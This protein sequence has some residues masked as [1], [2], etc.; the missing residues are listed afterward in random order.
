LAAFAPDGQKLWGM[1]LERTGIGSCLPER[2][3]SGR[4]LVVRCFDW[5]LRRFQILGE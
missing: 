5:Y 1:N 2:V 4:R 3:L